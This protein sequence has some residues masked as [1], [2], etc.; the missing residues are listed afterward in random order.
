MVR[1]TWQ[2]VCAKEG[3]GVPDEPA[4]VVGRISV[5]APL[6]DVDLLELVDF[7]L[8]LPAGSLP[9]ENCGIWIRELCHSP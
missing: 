5:C 8:P 9:S 2:P 6:V 4:F 1:N 7:P 3:I